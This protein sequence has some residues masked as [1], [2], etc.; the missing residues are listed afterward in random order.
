[1]FLYPANQKPEKFKQSFYPFS[2]LSYEASIIIIII[3]IA[4]HIMPTTSRLPLLHAPRLR[5]HIKHNNDCC[6]KAIENG[7]GF[8][9]TQIKCMD[10]MKWHGVLSGTCTPHWRKITQVIMV[11]ANRSRTY[12]ESIKYKKY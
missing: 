7:H 8:G 5:A 4:I 2:F 10:K 12:N 3:H 9:P 11:C 6:N 1:M